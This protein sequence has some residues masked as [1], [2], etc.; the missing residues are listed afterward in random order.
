[1]V[2]DMGDCV[3]RFVSG[4]G[5]HLV[6]ECLTA[7]LQDGMTI[8]HIQ[9]HA[10]NL[11][12]QHQPQR[13]ERYSDGG[14]SA[15]NTPPRFVD[16]RF[17][18]PTYSGPEQGSKVSGSQHRADFNKIGQPP[19]RCPRCGRLHA[20]RCYLDTGACFACGRTDHL[21]RDC[22]LRYEGDRAEPVGSAVGSSLTV[23]PP[24]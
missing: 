17:D 16:R 11:E 18:H 9:A 1:M 10:Q 2:A 14:Q 5:P 6:K 22:L 24:G 3:H 12:E 7:S 4:L 23:R 21:M 15:A 19:L 20:G 8:A 13:G